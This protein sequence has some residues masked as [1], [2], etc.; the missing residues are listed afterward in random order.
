MKSGD[1][2]VF[3]KAYKQRGLSPKNKLLDVLKDLAKHPE[4]RRF[5][6]FKLSAV[7]LLLDKPTEATMAPIIQAWNDSDGNLP[8]IHNALLKVVYDYSDKEMKFQT[9][10]QVATDGLHDS[11]TGLIRQVT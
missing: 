11:G 3:G 1:H 5:I 6:A 10:K 8:S 4:T 7:I 2:K 9:Q